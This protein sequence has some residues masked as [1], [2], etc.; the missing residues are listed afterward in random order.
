MPQLDRNGAARIRRPVTVG[1]FFSLGHSTI[2]VTTTIII[3]ISAQIADKLDVYGDVGGIIGAA[4]SGSFLVLIGCINTVILYRTWS[5]LRATKRKRECSSADGEPHHDPTPRFHGFL[6]RLAMPLLRTVDRPWKLYPVGLLFGLGFD[7]ASSI[8]LLSVAVIAQQ[9]GGGATSSG[10][11]NVVL[12]ALLFTA[13][14]TL[15][16]SADSC[17]MIW[18][19]APDLTRNG[20]KRLSI[21]EPQKEEKENIEQAD[22]N[23][24]AAIDNDEGRKQAS[25]VQEQHLGA[26][27]EGIVAELEGRTGQETDSRAEKAEEPQAAALEAQTN[28]NDSTSPDSLL[29]SLDESASRLSLVLTFLSILIAFAIGFIVLLGLIGDQCSRC[30]QAADRQAENGNGGLE[31][32]WWLAWRRANDNSGYV[33]AAIVGL[34]AAAVV[35]YFS[36]RWLRRRNKGT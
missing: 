19:Y 18:A 21:W 27:D 35:G 23:E 16:D 14:M 12:L 4:I 7:T 25:A 33:G 10:N 11:G 17:L 6:T 5:R 32:R 22:T 15:V 13:G 31:G 20:K 1:L 30:S 29:A 26:G 24:A 36:I 2:V 8:A 3:A 34:F 28:N 9:E